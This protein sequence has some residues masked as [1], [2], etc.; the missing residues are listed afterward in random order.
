MLQ[1]SCGGA[2]SSDFGSE[3][4][5]FLQIAALPATINA[6]AHSAARHRG[7]GLAAIEH[8]LQCDRI[9]LRVAAL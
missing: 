5:A 4:H 1:S 6:A 3:R 8:A 7:T 2:A 9:G